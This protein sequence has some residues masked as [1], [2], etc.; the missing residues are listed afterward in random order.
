VS[1]IACEHC[2]SEGVVKYGIYK[3]VQ[4]YWCKVCKRK[5]SRLLKNALECR[6]SRGNQ[7]QWGKRET[8]DEQC[9][10]G[11]NPG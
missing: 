2:G 10:D 11:E 4:R 7:V 8:E 3:G 6:E 1:E 9:V 5:S